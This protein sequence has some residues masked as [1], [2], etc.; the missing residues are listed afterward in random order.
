MN[1]LQNLD[2]IV[3]ETYNNKAKYKKKLPYFKIINYK[4][5]QLGLGLFHPRSLKVV[6][7][8]RVES[9]VG[10]LIACNFLNSLFINVKFGNLF[11]ETYIYMIKI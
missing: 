6:V 9:R 3:K 1:L 5:F 11:F 4:C 2:V 7:G 8:S 10:A